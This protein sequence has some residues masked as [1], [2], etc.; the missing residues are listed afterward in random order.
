MVGF[1]LAAVLQAAQ[2]VG[3]G[4]GPAPAAAKTWPTHEQ[5][6]VLRNFRFRD[7]EELLMNFV[8]DGVLLRDMVAISEG[9]DRRHEDDE[10][11]QQRIWSSG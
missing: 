11:E 9:G 3:W 10:Q 5:D 7:G 2:P 8:L 4:G 6:V 1:L